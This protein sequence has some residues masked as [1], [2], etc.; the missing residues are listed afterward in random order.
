MDSR[1]HIKSL[2]SSDDSSVKSEM[3][4]TS[5]TLEQSVLLRSSEFSSPEKEPSQLCQSAG[6]AGLKPTHPYDFQNSNIRN[7]PLLQL[8]KVVDN[9]A[10]TPAPNDH[11]ARR[12][13]FTEPSKSHS[14]SRG[15]RLDFRTFL[16]FI[17]CNSMET[18]SLRI[19]WRQLCRFPRD[20]CRP[21][22]SILKR[23]QASHCLAALCHASLMLFT[24]SRA[25]RQGAG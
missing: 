12:R 2:K 9:D 3:R 23:C 21:A 10:F 20:L 8:H 18:C 1:K 7:I 11:K 25:A 5:E 22:E 17:S 19:F 14:S 4:L 15:K 6:T 24:V 13:E 16:I